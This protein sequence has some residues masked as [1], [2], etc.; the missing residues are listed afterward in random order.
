VTFYGV[1]DAGIDEAGSLAGCETSFDGEKARIS[2]LSG[3]SSVIDLIRIATELDPGWA[4]G[5]DVHVACSSTCLA[6]ISAAKSSAFLEVL[7]YSQH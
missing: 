2:N 6:E 5:V 3:E 4:C 7:R 1:F